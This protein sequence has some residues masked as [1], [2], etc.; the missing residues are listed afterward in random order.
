MLRSGPVNLTALLA[1]VHRAAQENEYTLSV[2]AMLQDQNQQ[3]REQVAAWEH[4]Y[5]TQRSGVL[6]MPAKDPAQ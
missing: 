6:V 1:E 5:P 2:V 4:R 3:L